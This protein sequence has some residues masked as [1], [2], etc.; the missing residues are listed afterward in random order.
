MLTCS[1]RITL[2]PDYLKL[3]MSGACLKMAVPGKTD[4]NSRRARA[5][6]EAD[7]NLI[8]FDERPNFSNK[9]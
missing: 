7:S 9:P 4:G 8:L 5:S 3:I 2:I 6:A 1:E